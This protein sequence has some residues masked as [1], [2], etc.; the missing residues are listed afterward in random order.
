MSH[1]LALAPRAGGFSLV[2]LLVTICVLGSIASI[3]ILAIGSLKENS[4]RTRDRRNAQEIVAIYTAA[5]AAG[6]NFVVDGDME[7]T[8]RNV[9]AG[10]VV[11][12]G[13]FAG[14]HFGLPGL[15]VR[16][17]ES[18]QAHLEI[19]GGELLYDP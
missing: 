9:V 16:E 2:E 17:Q 14:S 3:A 13:A 15:D 4:S 6:L 1:R 19:S 18:A 8:V 7:Q 11:T 5:R 10:G 12:E